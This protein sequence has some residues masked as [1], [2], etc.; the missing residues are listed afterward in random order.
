MNRKDIL[1]FAI[2]ILLGIYLYQTREK[3]TNV[4]RSESEAESE[5]L[6]PWCFLPEDRGKCKPGQNCLKQDCEELCISKK[7]AAVYR[8][9][10]TCA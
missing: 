10:G 3:N 9:I 6:S 5:T 8:N 1:L 4:A 7:T 2:L